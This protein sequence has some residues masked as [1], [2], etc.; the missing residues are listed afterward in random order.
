MHAFPH[1]HH[2]CLRSGEFLRERDLAGRAIATRTHPAAGFTFIE[3]LVTLLITS[4]IAA[5][6]VT[7]FVLHQQAQMQQDMAVELEQNLR[8]GMTMISETLRAAGFGVPDGD[9]SPW[10]SGMTENPLVTGSDPPQLKVASASASVGSLASPISADATDASITL[11]GDETL[12]PGD[13]VRIGE[14]NAVLGDGGSID[15]DPSRSGSQPLG[16]A[17]PAGTEICHV[18]YLVFGID[19]DATGRSRLFVDK[20]EAGR[21][22]LAQYVYDLEVNE[23]GTNEYQIT[24]RARSDTVDPL[25]QM[26]MEQSLSS[27]VVARN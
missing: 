25:T 8:M 1:T 17:Y 23:L 2:R 10:I 4:V 13:I 18:D 5:G 24:L 20:N 12:E 6:F 3:L 15:G 22:T 16:R 9:L 11:E 21:V 27:V 14:D 26:H 7:S 19:T